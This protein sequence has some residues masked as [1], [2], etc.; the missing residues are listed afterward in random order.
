MALY[1]PYSHAARFSF[2]LRV[3]EEKNKLCSIFISKTP[4]SVMVPLIRH[5]DGANQP[6]HN[7]PGSKT[8]ERLSNP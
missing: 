4:S 3:W 2:P 1:S 7:L 8:Y 5:P 6:T